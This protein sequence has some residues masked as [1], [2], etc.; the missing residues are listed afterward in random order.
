MHAQVADGQLVLETGA[1]VRALPDRRPKSY[2][3]DTTFST[4]APVEWSARVKGSSRRKVSQPSATAL[5]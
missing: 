1:G 3:P 4:S 5:V 2:S